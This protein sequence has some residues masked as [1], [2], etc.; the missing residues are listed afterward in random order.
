MNIEQEE[1]K[2]TI[3]RS[4]K[5]AFVLTCLIYIL[6]NYQRFV[7]QFNHKHKIISFIYLFILMSITMTTVEISTPQLSTNIM[8]GI[9]WGIG[10]AL[11]NKILYYK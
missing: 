10:A 11:L 2:E 4:T 8:Y 3:I 7:S 9:G 6:Y 1:Q 5:R